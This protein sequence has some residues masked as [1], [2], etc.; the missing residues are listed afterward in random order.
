V[1]RRRRSL[2]ALLAIVAAV[3]GGQ[4]RGAT[5][6]SIYVDYDDDCVFSMHADGGF[7]LA[8]TAAPGTTIPPGAYQVV[9]RVPQN[10]PTCP[11][12]FELQGPGVQLE[13]DFAGEA[14]GA[15]VTETLKPSSTYVATDLRN[16]SR[17]RA[18]FSTAATGSGASLVTQTPSTAT[19]KGQASTDVVGSAVVR[20]RGVLDVT[21]G[22]S[23]AVTLRAKGRVVRSLETGRYDLAVDDR[24]ARGGLTLRK[25]N[26]DT[27]TLSGAAFVGARRTSLVLRPGTWRFAG[28]GHAVA[29][30]VVA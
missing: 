12:Q 4:G 1:G 25:P 6:P 8:S 29:L 14:L 17:Y 3:S 18:V 15:Q 27:L 28:A 19:D 11:L 10:A 7:V 24:T 2:V 5:L 20:Y 9:L 21:V 22:A 23:G 26:R 30:T 16:P 13:W